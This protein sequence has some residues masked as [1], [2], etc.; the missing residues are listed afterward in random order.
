MA[1]NR[2]LLLGAFFVIVFG[3]LGAYTLFWTDFSVFKERH[4]LVVH[5]ADGNGIRKGDAVLV[6][7]IRMGRV[8]YRAYDPLA[9]LD[10]R[11]TVTLSLDEEVALREG[12]VIAIED[13]TMLGGKQVVVDPGPPGG[14]PVATD[15]SL[16]GVVRGG[17][18]DGISDVVQRN[19]ER[20]EAL[21]TDA[22]EIAAALRRTDLGPAG[23]I[24]NDPELGEK[25]VETVNDAKRSFEN[26]DAVTTA[27]REGN[28]VIGRLIRDEELA[29][30]L[31]EVITNLR[32]ISVDFKTAMADVEAGKGVIGMLA[33]DDALAEDVRA[34]V[35]KIEEITNRINSGEGA[36]WKLIEDEGIAR[37]IQE[38]GDKIDQ[39]TLGKLVTNDEVYVK[40]S[41][42]ADDIAAATGAIRNAEGSLGKIVMQDDLYEQIDRALGILT[43]TLQEYREAAPIT[44]FTSVLFYGF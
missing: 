31:D 13:A 24:I 26:I 10:R 2:Q 8:Q 4:E 1:V 25:L 43:R 21:L 15:E 29:V 34:A 42:I 11:V 19:G 20:F 12:Y 17:P 38:L 40:L 28:G 3:I 35:S 36:L 41:K 5:F 32:Q 37:K 9:P 16:P 33:K 6:A 22:A 30:E 18:L 44:T 7:G 14:A 39:G 27:L 23:R